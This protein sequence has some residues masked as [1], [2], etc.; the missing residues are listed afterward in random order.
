MYIVFETLA[1]NDPRLDPKMNIFGKYWHY[2]IA[3]IAPEHEESV[4]LKWMPHEVISE[5][6]A[7][8]DKLASSIDGEIALLVKN[9]GTYEEIIAPTSGGDNNYRKQLYYLTPEDDKNCTDLLKAIAKIHILTKLSADNEPNVKERLLTM[10]SQLTNLNDAQVFF[11]NYFGVQ[12]TAY[13]HKL[14]NTAEF[15]AKFNL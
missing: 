2:S 3:F 11:H 7:K 10:V 8:S 14:E 6:V 5:K 1:S 9:F 4:Y 12:L 13:T 15:T